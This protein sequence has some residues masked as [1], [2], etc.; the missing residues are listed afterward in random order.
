MGTG[1]HEPAKANAAAILPKPVPTLRE[2][3]APREAR[4]A[5]N[6]PEARTSD[7]LSALA[8]PFHPDP[9][10]ALRNSMQSFFGRDHIFF[11]P[12]GQCAIAQLVAM[13]PQKEVVMPAY[14]CYQVRHAIAAVGKKIIYVDLAKNGVNSMAAQFEEAAKPGRILLAAH[15]Y[16]VP[17]DI[18]A[19]CDLAKRRDCVTIEDAVPAFSGRQKGRLLGTIA[20][21][22]VFSFHHSKRMS[23]FSGAM[24]VANNSRVISTSTLDAFRLMKTK[25]EFPLTDLIF[26]FVQNIGTAPWIYRNLTL[27]LL[28]LREVLPTIL[29]RFQSKAGT[30]VEGTGGE[31]QFSIPNNR[32]FSREVHA[33]QAEILLRMM[34]RMTGIRDHISGLVRVYQERFQN[35]SIESLVPD[36]CDT[37]AFMRFPVMFAG[38]ERDEVMSRAAR[39]GVQLKSGWRGTLSEESEASRFPNATLIAKRLTVL[40][41]YTGLTLESADSLA[42]TLV[43]IA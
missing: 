17:T 20:D 23:A 24:V 29:H 14:M 2:F 43:K 15:L 9:L 31:K 26:G 40:P 4:I 6:R 5:F 42:R 8:Y 16:G 35:T 10:A 30:A 27:P 36:G 11:A 1:T 12:S 3:C 19:I 33:Y 7:L 32:F 34:N 39:T 41:L 37:G 38:R 13:L 25:R 21:F 22:G 28:P 18:E